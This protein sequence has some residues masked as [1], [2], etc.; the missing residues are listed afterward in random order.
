ML[1]PLNTPRPSQVELMERICKK[2]RFK[3]HH[4]L[5]ANPMLASFYTNLEALVY[6]EEVEEAKDV[7]LP[8]CDDQD[9]KLSEFV[10]DIAEEFGTV[11]LDKYSLV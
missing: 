11:I 1:V 9:K 6:D 8:P 2:L 10:D 7:T 5:F 4:D 3:Y